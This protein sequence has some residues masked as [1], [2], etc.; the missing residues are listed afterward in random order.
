[1]SFGYYAHSVNTTRIKDD[2]A[3]LILMA[4]LE[5]IGIFSLYALTIRLVLMFPW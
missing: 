2:G 1:M 4:I 5:I 3:N